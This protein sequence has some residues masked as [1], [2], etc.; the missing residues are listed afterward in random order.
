MILARKTHGREYGVGV[1]QKLVHATQAVGRVVTAMV[2]SNPLRV[3][4]EVREARLAVCRACELWR[5]SA[6]L[7]LGEC[8]HPQC[9]CTRFK[10]GLATERCPLKLW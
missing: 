6:N 7:G 3:S 10:H 8:R 1:T 9:G 5:E 2:A 4:H